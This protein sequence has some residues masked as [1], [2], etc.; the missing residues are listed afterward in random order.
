MFAFEKSFMV[1]RSLISKS[2]IATRK[3]G[4]DRASIV[5]SDIALNAVVS[6]AQMKDLLENARGMVAR[7]GTLIVQDSFEVGLYLSC[8]FRKN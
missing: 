2:G 8:H 4:N 6:P 1:N 3:P 7:M 5:Q